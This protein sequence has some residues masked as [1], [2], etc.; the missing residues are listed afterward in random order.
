LPDQLPASS[1]E[2]NC[3]A[4]RTARG[5]EHAYFVGRAAGYPV[6]MEGALKLKEVSYLHAEAYSAAEL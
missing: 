3:R 6:A 2:L 1:R 5:C 4:C